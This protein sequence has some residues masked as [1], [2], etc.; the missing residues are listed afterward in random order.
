MESHVRINEIALD[1][2]NHTPSDAVGIGNEGVTSV[3][4]R[5]PFDSTQNLYIGW[6]QQANTGNAL[7]PGSSV[8]YEQDGY[9]LKDNSLYVNW[10]GSSGGKALISVMTEHCD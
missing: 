2:S 9:D 5:N 6:N 7:V 8:T 10:S 3:T 1:Q 4:I